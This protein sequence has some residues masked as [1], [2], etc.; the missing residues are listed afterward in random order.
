MAKIRE[1][2]KKSFIMYVDYQSDFEEMTGDE[3]KELMMIIFNYERIHKEPVIQDR[4]MRMAWG[5]IKRDLDR[6]DSAWLETKEKLSEAGKKGAEKRWHSDDGHPIASDSHPINGMASMAVNDNENVN[7]N[8]NVNEFIG[9]GS[10]RTSPICTESADREIDYNNS[11]AELAYIKD[12]DEEGV[13]DIDP[14]LEKSLQLLESQFIQEKESCYEIAEDIWNK[15][16]VS[17]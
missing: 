3:C 13:E 15:I 8:L 7:V 9:I 6:N 4:F 17:A 16:E 5:R 12:I 1:E 10:E 14:R 11:D 2:D